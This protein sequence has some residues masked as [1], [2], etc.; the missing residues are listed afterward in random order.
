MDF[1]SAD[2]KTEPRRRQ[3][4]DTAGKPNRR[5]SRSNDYE[6]EGKP[7]NAGDLRNLTHMFLKKYELGGLS[8]QHAIHCALSM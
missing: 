5:D 2:T 8:P 6:I 1:M 7:A 4:A 3:T